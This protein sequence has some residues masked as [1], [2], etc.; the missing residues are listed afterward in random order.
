M[1]GIIMRCIVPMILIGIAQTVIAQVAAVKMV[2]KVPYDTA[3]GMSVYIAGSFNNWK[4]G[5]SLFQLHA[6]DNGLYAITLPLFSNKHYE[7]KYTRGNWSNAEVGTNDSDIHNRMFVS[8]D[9]LVITDTVAAW[10][11]E[12]KSEP[13][14]QQAHINAI[15][16]STVAALKPQLNELLDLLKSHVQNWLSDKPS[17]DVQKTLNEEAEK[18]LN[19]VFEQIVGL[20]GN[21][22]ATLTPEQKAE[23]K[24]LI[25]APE[26]K[27]DF[28]NTLGNGIQKVTSSLK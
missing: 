15:K 10:K 17:A 25:D 3:T 9:D 5:D 13:S 21:V 19:D 16:D 24:K 12:I 4:A 18:K 27:N 22:I 26:D 2:V 28:I 23:L 20:L 7:Y 14:P 6:G 8:S 1:K 11:K